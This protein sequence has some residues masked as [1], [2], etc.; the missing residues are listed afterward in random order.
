MLAVVPSDVVS[1]LEAWI[2]LALLNTP[3][4]DIAVYGDSAGICKGIVDMVRAIPEELILLDGAARAKL[5]LALAR[6]EFYIERSKLGQPDT[7]PLCQGH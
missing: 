5:M 1:Y 2:G 4:A 7:P 3:N 6:I